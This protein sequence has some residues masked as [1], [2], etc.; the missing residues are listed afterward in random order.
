[1]AWAEFGVAAAFL[2]SARFVPSKGFAFITLD[3]GASLGLTC[4]TT[5]TEAEKILSERI[6]KG[7]LMITVPGRNGR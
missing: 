7:L 1:M 5:H 3:T 2:S 6:Q 4:E